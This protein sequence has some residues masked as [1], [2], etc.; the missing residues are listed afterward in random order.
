MHI[1]FSGIG[2]AGIGPLALIAKQAGYE[3]SG[4]DLKS[5]QYINY[6]VEKGITD[7]HIGQTADDIA[8]IQQRKP[9]DWFV[10]S[11]ALPLTNPNHE[12]LAFADTKALKAVNAT[13]SCASC[14]S[15]R[16]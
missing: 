15:K 13:S 7:I 8:K 2:G 3:V 11:S 10:Y 12:E 4:S 1:F 16:A 14:W 6:L 9:I 5:G